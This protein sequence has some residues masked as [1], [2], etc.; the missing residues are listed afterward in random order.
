MLSSK[1]LSRNLDL[2]YAP[3]GP[4]RRDSMTETLLCFMDGRFAFPSTNHPKKVD[5]GPIF[6]LFVYL[7]RESL[8]ALCGAQERSR[9]PAGVGHLVGMSAWLQELH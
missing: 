3:F 5:N 8:W 1:I 2:R 4:S 7:C 6:R 9:S